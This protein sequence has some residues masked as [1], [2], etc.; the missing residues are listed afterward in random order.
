MAETKNLC[1]QVPLDLH[2]KVCEAKER[3]GITTS[4]YMTGLLR[5]YCTIFCTQEK[6]GVTNMENS[7]TMAFQIPEELF[8]RIK[9]H[10]EHESARL[11]RKVTQREF[12]LGLIESALAQAEAGEAAA[13]EHEDS[14]M[15]DT[16]QEPAQGAE[17]AEE[18]SPQP[19]E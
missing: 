13:Q 18:V 4:K 10:L 9:R 7:R 14:I 5:T 17:N 15:P 8:Q 2:A 1:A 19:E 16:D 3:L 11:G 12:V 6:K